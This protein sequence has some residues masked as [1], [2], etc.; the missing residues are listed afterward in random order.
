[1]TDLTAVGRLRG[2]V[3]PQRHQGHP[4]HRRGR[5][6]RHPRGHA[7]EG[8]RHP[9]GRL[10]GR[11]VGPRRHGPRPLLHVGRRR[12]LRQRHHGA[13]DR[14]GPTPLRRRRLP[15]GAALV[16]AGRGRRRLRRPGAGP[17]G[18]GRR[19]RGWL[20]FG[21][22]GLASPALLYALD[23]WEHAPGLGLMAW[24]VVAMVDTAAGRARWT[25]AGRRPG[26]RGGVLHAHRGGGLRLRRGRRRLRAALAAAG[27]RPG[28]G[29]RGA[30]RRR[31][32]SPWS[33]PTTCWRWRAR[34]VAAHRPGVGHG[35][36]RRLRPRRAPPGGRH[37]HRRAVPQHRHRPTAHRR[38]A[39]LLL[40]WAVWRASRPGDPRVARIAA[41]GAVLLFLLRAVDGLG[42][43]PGFLVTA[44]FGVVA[45]VLVTDRRVARAAATP[46]SW[47]WWPS[48]WSGCSSS[49]GARC[50]SGVGATCSPRAWCSPPSASACRVC[51]TGGCATC[52]S[53]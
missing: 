24:G 38:L 16:D 5:Q 40:A 17:A 20:A 46:W 43:V 4:Q 30:R 45:L 1:M 32:S 49:A 8:H 22:I 23:L 27:L 35:V 19:A 33:P 53:A 14:A 39:V 6:D 31:A 41:V 36:G 50:R 3:V 2:P 47:W 44:P 52:S 48:R 9:G 7:G 12:H 28:A 18:R 15:G 37:H 34:G 10:L 29:G 25:R 42:F 51:S 26:L 21:L 11:R 13:G